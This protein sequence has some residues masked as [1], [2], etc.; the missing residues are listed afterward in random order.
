MVQSSLFSEVKAGQVELA[1]L[2]IFDI[3]VSQYVQADRID[4]IYTS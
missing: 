3:V 2:E 1:T 4:C